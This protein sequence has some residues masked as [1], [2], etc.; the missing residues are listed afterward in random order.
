MAFVKDVRLRYAAK[1]LCRTNLPVSVIASKSGYA[2]RTH[3][4]RTFRASYGLDL[5]SFRAGDVVTSERK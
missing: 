5:Q 3:F 1:L 2:S 4:S